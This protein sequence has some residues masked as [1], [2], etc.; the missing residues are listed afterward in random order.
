MNT[1][2]VVR[3]GL[4]LARRQVW[5]GGRLRRGA[6]PLVLVTLFA[7]VTWFGLG[8]WF[9]ALAEAHASESYAARLLA[10]TFTL[11]SVMTFVSGLHVAVSALVTDRDLERLIVA[12][13]PSG[14][15]LAIKCAATL[16]RTLPPIIGIALPAACAY[17]ATWPVRSSALVAGL[18]LALLTLWAVPLALAVLVALPLLRLAPPTRLRE[19]LAVLATAAFLAGWLAN[20]FWVPHVLSDGRALA[21]SLRQLPAPPHSSPATWAAQLLTEAAPTRAALG[22]A[23][24]L[25]VTVTLAA[26][27][28][29]GLLATLH[30]RLAEA[31]GRIVH[32]RARRAS[33]L[34]LAFLQRDAALAARDW[35]VLLDALAQFALWTLLPLAVLPVAPLPPLELARAMLIALGVSLGN[36]VAARALPLE[37]DALVW[38]RLSPIGGARWVRLRALGV[39]VVALG[40]L[41]IATALVSRAL[42]LDA[43]ETLDAFAVA[44]A[45]AT[46]LCGAGLA[47]GAHLGDPAWT[48]PRA[49]LGPGGRSAA[50]A[51]LLSLAAGWL[52]ISHV[53]STLQ[54][55]PVVVLAGLVLLGAVLGGAGLML[56][57]RRIE[58]QEFTSR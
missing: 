30:A 12:P 17:A 51:T 58:G 55:N 44:V 28:A 27:F 46:S 8:T 5:H 6:L 53:S 47:L 10:W 54:P 56:A 24:V 14:A 41:V 7:L 33:S 29:R 19:S 9:E 43:G 52:A 48:D 25:L 35:P 31:T 23:L 37:R 40:V 34:A 16:P 15:L 32:A 4:T 2:V 39:A 13:V 21:E 22:C 38:A 49:M 36:D 1:V 18:P 11:A 42:H 26:H 57:A 3:T 50:A 20:A 45:A